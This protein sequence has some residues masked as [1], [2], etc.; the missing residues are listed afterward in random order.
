MALCRKT[1]QESDVESDWFE[2]GVQWPSVKKQREKGLIIMYLFKTFFSALDC[3]LFLSFQANTSGNTS[4]PR[5]LERN[6]YSEAQ[7]RY[8]QV[9]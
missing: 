9:Q 6:L 8:H 5:S 4:L 3:Q 2:L 1:V 7:T